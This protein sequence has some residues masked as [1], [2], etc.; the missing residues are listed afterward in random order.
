MWFR[1]AKDEGVKFKTYFNPMPLEIIA[2]VFT[3]VMWSSPFELP[4]LIFFSRLNILSNNGQRE[5]IATWAP[6]QQ[7]TTRL[8]LSVTSHLFNRPKI[9]VLH[10]HKSCLTSK[11]SGLI[12]P[13]LSF[14]IIVYSIWPFFLVNLR[15]SNRREISRCL[16]MKILP[17]LSKTIVV[18]KAKN[19][20]FKFVIC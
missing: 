13:G 11:S 19:E 8:S 18:M 16:M 14:Y 5:H 20:S 1:D 17:R 3:T 7:K 10:L 9:T 6:S 2:L 15:V 4:S 12:G